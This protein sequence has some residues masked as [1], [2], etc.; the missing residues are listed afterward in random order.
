VTVLTDKNIKRKRGGGG[1]YVLTKTEPMCMI[2]R[3]SYFTRRRR[4]DNTSVP[5][6]INNEIA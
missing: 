1:A 2:Y 6:V 5:F 4:D 3:I